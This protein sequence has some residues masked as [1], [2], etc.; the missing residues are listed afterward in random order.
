MTNSPFRLFPLLFHKSY[1]APA[2]FAYFDMHCHML[3][4]VDDG[5]TDETEMCAMLEMAYKDGTRSVCFTPHYSPYHYG[6]NSEVSTTAF[7]CAK[8]TAKK[9]SD[10]KLYLANEMGYYGACFSDL[11][12][13]RCRTLEG[14]RNLLVDF[15]ASVNAFELKNSLSQLTRQ[16]YCPVLAH[17]ERYACLRE[18]VS[19][20]KRLEYIREFRAEGVAIQV[21]AESVAG[22]AGKKAQAY[23]RL[24]FD[25]ALVQLICSDAHHAKG[26]VPL[27]SVCRPFLD[28]RY[29]A[30]YIRA[31]L[32]DNAVSLMRGENIFDSNKESEEEES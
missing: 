28:G 26:R 29:P 30:A 9:Y 16:G 2:P 11:Q 24:L 32:H 19:N 27:L 15:P 18:G 4:G 13:G 22:A 25:H 10:L 21:N 14:S 31:L 12:S 3:P 20:K 8:R 17:T 7:L 1:E 23:C 5:A 6:D